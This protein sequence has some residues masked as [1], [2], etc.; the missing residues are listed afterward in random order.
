MLHRLLCA[1]AVEGMPLGE[2]DAYCEC[3]KGTDRSPPGPILVI[4]SEVSRLELFTLRLV[5][6]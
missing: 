1:R 3:F 5:D 4:Q 2:G 6:T